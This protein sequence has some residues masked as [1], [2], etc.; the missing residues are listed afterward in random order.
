MASEE[1]GVPLDSAE[2]LEDRRAQE[3]RATEG[4]KTEVPASPSQD[5]PQVTAGNVLSFSW[6][7]CALL[8]G[9]DI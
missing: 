2:N 7:L 1:T 4:P 8:V 9:V 6:I 5:G 3:H